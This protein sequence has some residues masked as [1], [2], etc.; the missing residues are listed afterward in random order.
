MAIDVERYIEVKEDEDTDFTRVCS[1]DD[2]TG[3]LDRR[4]FFTMVCST[5]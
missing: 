1:D 4:V 2:V 5:S 3:D